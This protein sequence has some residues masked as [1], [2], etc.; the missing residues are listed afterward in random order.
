[1]FYIKILPHRSRESGRER[2]ISC[3]DYHLQPIREVLE[4]EEEPSIVGIT[5]THQN[6]HCGGSWRHLDVDEP[7]TVYVMSNTGDNLSVRSF[8]GTGV[9]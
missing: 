9:T 8:D 4:G 6:E 3:T 5:I 1:M 2:G 7:A